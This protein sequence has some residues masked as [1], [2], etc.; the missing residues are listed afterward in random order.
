MMCF[1]SK[2]N[3]VYLLFLVLEGLSIIYDIQVKKLSYSPHVFGV[4][5]AW[6]FK[7]K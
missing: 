6:V 4:R 1:V 3:N 7:K 2:E 5:K